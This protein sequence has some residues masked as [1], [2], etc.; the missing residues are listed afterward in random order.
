MRKRCQTYKQNQYAYTTDIGKQRGQN[1]EACGDTCEH[2]VVYKPSNT[3]FS[4]RGAVN[5]DTRTERLKYVTVSSQE[6]YLTNR[7]KPVLQDSICHRYHRNGNKTNC[8]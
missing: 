4:Q 3:V 1:S 7:L 6:K 5:S 2:T 8:D